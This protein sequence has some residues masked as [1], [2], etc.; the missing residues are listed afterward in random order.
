MALT[1]QLLEWAMQSLVL[2]IAVLFLAAILTADSLGALSAGFVLVGLAVLVA[3]VWIIPG[4]SIEGISPWLPVTSELWIA[5]GL[6]VLTLVWWAV[7]AR[8]Q[9][10]RQSGSSIARDVR[11]RSERLFD[12]YAKIFRIFAG[13][14]A[15]GFV[16][17]AGDAAAVFLGEVVG[18][19]AANPVITSHLTAIPLVYIG[20]GGVLQVPLIG[21]V[22]GPVLSS[23][24]LGFVLTVMAGFAIG[25]RFA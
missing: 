4:V 17:I 21:A 10:G 11:R 2:T 1:D 5:A 20:T 19:A 13:M 25:A 7:L 12:S 18:L 3:L 6:I 14:V 24:V 8:F 22:S 16:A 9:K 15:V 23:T